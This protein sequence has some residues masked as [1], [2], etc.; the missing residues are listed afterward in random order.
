MSKASD[1]KDIDIHVAEKGDDHPYESASD[2]ASLETP[3]EPNSV[4]GRPI[5]SMYLKR[6]EEE[7]G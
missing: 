1:S 3:E 7:A 5:Y 2:K 6:A 4:D